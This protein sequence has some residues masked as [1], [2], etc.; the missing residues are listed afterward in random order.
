MYTMMS[1]RRLATDELQ[2][3][4]LPQSDWHVLPLSLHA[5]GAHIS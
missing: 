5:E 2:S 1:H 4:I 3:K